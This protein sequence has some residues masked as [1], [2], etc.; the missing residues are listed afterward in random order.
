MTHVFLLMLAMQHPLWQDI[1]ILSSAADATSTPR[2]RVAA[3]L[4]KIEKSIL[5]ACK[6]MPAG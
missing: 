6:V 2:Q 4:T 5:M 3:R 1:E